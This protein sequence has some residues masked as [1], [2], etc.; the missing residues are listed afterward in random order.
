MNHLLSKQL[1]KMPTLIFSKTNNIFLRGALRVNLIYIILLGALRINLRSFFFCR[2]YWYSRA[3][4]KIEKNICL[5]EGNKSFGKG[6]SLPCFVY[7]RVLLIKL[8]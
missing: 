2:Q 6:A 8:P 4:E 1:H 7:S 3:K 5:C